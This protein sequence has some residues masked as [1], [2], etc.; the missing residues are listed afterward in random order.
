MAP[1]PVRVP[2]HTPAPARTRLTVSPPPPAGPAAG[3]SCDEAGHYINS[4][5]VCVPRPVAAATAPAGV[6]AKC[7]DGEYSFSKHRQGT[8]S[9][10]GGVAQWL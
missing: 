7:K 6:T 3:S 2:V 1:T 4:N 8:C 10:H 5:G 9:G